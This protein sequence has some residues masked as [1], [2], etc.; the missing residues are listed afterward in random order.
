MT[1]VKE[2]RLGL[3][4]ECFPPTFPQSHTEEQNVI[5]SRRGKKW[6]FTKQ[7]L[8][9]L[10]RMSNSEQLSGI[11]RVDVSTEIALYHFIP[12]SQTRGEPFYT[13]GT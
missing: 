9:P 1:N 2:Y 5:I 12:S 8:D 10:I 7:V 3:Q 6:L 4:Q 11:R 13:T